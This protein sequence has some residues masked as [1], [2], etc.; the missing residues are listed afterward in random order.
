MKLRNILVITLIGVVVLGALTFAVSAQESSTA[1]VSA[2]EAYTKLNQDIKTLERGAQKE[3]APGRRMEIIEEIETMLTEFVEEY[4][5]T[6]EAVDAKFQLGIVSFGLQKT[7]KAI[8]Y[9]NDFLISTTDAEL[10]KQVFA[11]Y[12]L[13]EAYKTAGD[14]D[15]AKREYNVVVDKYSDVQPKVVQMAKRS[16]ENL[17]FDRK[18]AIGN[19]PID[20]SVK[21]LDGET[22]SPGK[23]KGKVLL[24][25]FWATWCGPCRQEMPNVKQV[26]NKYKDKGFE[27]VGISLDRNRADLDKY[28][29]SNNITWPQVFDGK[30]WQNDVAVKY[31]VQSIPAT[32]LIDKKGKIRYKTLRGKHLETA[33]KKLLD[34]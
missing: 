26:Y 24:L 14:F 1:A 4:P 6:P 34:E 30:F 33:V 11:H 22:I 5:G 20:F 18:L 21:S 9:L 19:Q 2:E 25:D 13:A 8:S 16:L 31:R 17:D 32:Y 27:I 28:I 29:E 12:Y 23:F 10:D 3:R 7:E 15:G